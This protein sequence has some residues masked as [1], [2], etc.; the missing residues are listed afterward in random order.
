MPI[1][2]QFMKKKKEQLENRESLPPFCPESFALK[3]AFLSSG[4]QQASYKNSV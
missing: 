2:A 3:F 1:P 4:H